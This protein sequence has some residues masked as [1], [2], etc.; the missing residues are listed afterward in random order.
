MSSAN[1]VRTIALAS[2]DA[3]ERTTVVDLN[4]SPIAT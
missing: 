1:T 4:W 3:E 2:A